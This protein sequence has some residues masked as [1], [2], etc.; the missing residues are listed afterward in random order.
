[1][2]PYHAA[3]VIW[4]D[5][6]QSALQLLITIVSSALCDCSLNKSTKP[7]TFQVF[8]RAAPANFEHNSRTEIGD[9]RDH[10]LLRQLMFLSHRRLIRVPIPSFCAEQQSIV[11]LW[12]MFH[13]QK[14]GKCCG[15]FLKSLD[16]AVL[17]VALHLAKDVL[18][19]IPRGVG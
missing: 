4:H 8:Y 7:V 12:S 15:D 2:T 18:A 1:M 13:C 5:F 9:N 17:G 16:D 10:Q 11:P 19:A 6:L 14:A 3:H